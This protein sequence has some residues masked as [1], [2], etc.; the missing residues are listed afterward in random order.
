MGWLDG[1]LG[2]KE[3]PKETKKVKTKAKKT[4]TE[5]KT[6]KEIVA[7]GPAKKIKTKTTWTKGKLDK[8]ST[9][10][11]HKVAKEHNIKIDGL[12]KT[13]IYSKIVKG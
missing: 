5:P 13:Q 2:S 1:I 8:L 7:K 4:K 9:S 12:T 3:T 10:E 11:L 6:K